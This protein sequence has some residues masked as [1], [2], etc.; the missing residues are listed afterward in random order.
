MWCHF[1]YRNIKCSILAISS[2]APQF[3]S[4]SSSALRLLY[5][6][7]LTST[8]NYGKSIDLTIWTFVGK[9]MFLLFNM[10]S[11][12]YVAVCLYV[13]IPFIPRSKH[14][15]ISQ[16]KSPSSDFGAQQNKIC[17]CFHV[18]LIYLPWRKLFHIKRYMVEPKSV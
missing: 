2:A 12:I 11:S 18:S 17:H 16:L 14:H 15:S 5:D 10:L 9:V 8:H 6:S 4:I 1:P 7:T 3:K 13:V